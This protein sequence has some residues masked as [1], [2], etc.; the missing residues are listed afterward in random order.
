VNGRSVYCLNVSGVQIDE[1][2][3]A[4]FPG[5]V[6]PAGLSASLRGAEQLQA[7]HDGVLA[8]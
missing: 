2:V 3:V 5:A 1:A 7:D 8:Q 4:A 6:A